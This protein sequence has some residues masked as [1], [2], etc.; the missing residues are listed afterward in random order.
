ML[1]QSADGST[2]DKSSA[3]ATREKKRLFSHTKYM[4]IAAALATASTATSHASTALCESSDDDDDEEEEEEEDDDDSE[5]LPR[6]LPPLARS[7]RALTALS[8]AA[9]Y[10]GSPLK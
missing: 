5:P 7:C 2:Q 3:G 8:R 1:G 10:A 9:S 4:L 6:T